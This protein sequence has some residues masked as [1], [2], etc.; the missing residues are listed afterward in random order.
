MDTEW[1]SGKYCENLMKRCVW[2]KRKLH[3]D[4]SRQWNSDKLMQSKISHDANRFLEMDLGFMLTTV[5][6]SSSSSNRENSFCPEM[7]IEYIIRHI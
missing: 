1:Q 4:W 7:E 5:Q 2:D 6:H 3:S